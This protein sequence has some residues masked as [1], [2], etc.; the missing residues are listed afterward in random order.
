[1][2]FEVH[3][4]GIDLVVFEEFGAGEAVLH[5]KDELQRNQLMNDPS[6]RRWFRK[7]YE[8]RFGPRVWQR[9]FHDAHI[10]GC[11]DASLIGKS[12]GQVA[13]ER[14]VHPV[15]CFL[16]LVVEHGRRLRWRTLIANHRPHRLKKIVQEKGA[17]LSFSDAGAHIRNMAFYN[18]PLRML[19]LVHDAEAEGRPFMSLEKAVWRLTGELGDWFDVDAGHLRLGDR[20]DLVIVDPRGLDDSLGT[21]AEAPIPEFNG[22]MRMVNRNDAAVAATVING[23]VAFRDGQF[24]ADYGLAQGYGRFLRAGEHPAREAAAAAMAQA[25]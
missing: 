17:I 7:N 24:A 11:P 22:L 10:V 19:K 15:D 2:P 12:F 23:R 5:L 13:D 20:A 9:D 14:G 3:A 4:D 8:K 16:D 18:F 6:Y 1:V 21:Y 25:A